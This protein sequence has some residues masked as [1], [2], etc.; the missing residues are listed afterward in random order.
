MKLGRNRSTVEVTVL[1]HP[2]EIDEEVVGRIGIA[3]SGQAN[4]VVRLSAVDSVARS[5]ETT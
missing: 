4:V 2:V 1:P 3:P 5:V